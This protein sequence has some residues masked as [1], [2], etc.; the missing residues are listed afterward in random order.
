MIFLRLIAVVITLIGLGMLLFAMLG[1][2]Q[3]S[4]NSLAT[5]GL[6]SMLAGLLLAM[7]ADAG[8][9]M[10]ERQKAAKAPPKKNGE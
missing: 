5:F 2:D 10:S 7:A 6:F 4:D 1:A 9:K 8:Q 3:N